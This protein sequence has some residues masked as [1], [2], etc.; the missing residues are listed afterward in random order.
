[1]ARPERIVSAMAVNGEEHIVARPDELKYT[2]QGIEKE[3]AFRDWD[4]EV[5][6]VVAKEYAKL[7]DLPPLTQ[8]EGAVG[9][10]LPCAATFKEVLR[11]KGEL[12][13]VCMNIC[14]ISHNFAIFTGDTIVME[15]VEKSGRHLFWD[16]AADRPSAP[17]AWPRGSPSGRED[18]CRISAT[19][20]GRA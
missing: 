1:M 12:R 14:S 16:G 17:P 20:H 13:N 10:K 9:Q 11:T 8:Q 19:A 7:K 2:I 3:H 4:K 18:P 15:V 5:W 6:K